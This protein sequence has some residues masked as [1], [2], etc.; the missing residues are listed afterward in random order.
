MPFKILA[1]VPS[2]AEPTPDGRSLAA[3]LPYL[4]LSKGMPGADDPCRVSVVRC[5]PWANPHDSSKLPRFL[6][7]GLTLYVLNNYTNKS[8]PY[9]VTE[10][11][12][13]VPVAQLEVEKI[14]SHCSVRGQG[15][16]KAIL[17]DT[18]WKG[19]LQSSWEQEMDLQHS[20]QHILHYWAGTPLQH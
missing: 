6:P 12:V 9:H 19:L 2:P 11:N 5:K 15:G 7:A 13:T 3:K 16:V 8:P 17:Y 18:L 20:R 4:D 10:D 1:I 14:T